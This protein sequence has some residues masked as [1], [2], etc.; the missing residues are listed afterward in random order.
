[1]FLITQGY[2]GA[3]VITQGYASGALRTLAA[4]WTPRGK[5]TTWNPASKPLAWTPAAKALTWTPERNA[6]MADTALL[7]DPS[8]N[9]K[10]TMNFGRQPELV[11]GDC[12]IQTCTCAVAPLTGFTGSISSSSVTVNGPLCTSFLSGGTDQ[13]DYGARF[14][15]TMLDA[16]GH[17][18]TRVLGGLVRVRQEAGSE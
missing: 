8:D 14:T 1:M 9:L 4:T 11:S 18:N 10:Y 16:G 5:L 17:T 12:T 3:L 6:F 2:L 13:N 15:A 7:K